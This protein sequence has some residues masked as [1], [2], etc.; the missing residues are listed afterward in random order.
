M[1]ITA[2]SIIKH[3]QI[4]LQDVTGKR[5]PASEL[6][7]YLNMS[8]RDIRDARPDVT[9]TNKVIAL[10]AGH[11]QVLPDD[12]ASLIDIPANAG[13]SKDRISL[14][15]VDLLDAQ[16]P[17]WRAN[18]RATKIQHF[19]YDLLVPNVFYTYPPANVGVQVELEAS[20]YPVDVAEPTV[21]GI[22]FSTVAGNI[23][24][25]DFCESVLR[26]MVLYYAYSKDAEYG[27]NMGLA[28]FYLKIATGLLGVEIKTKVDIKREP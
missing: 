27:G 10:T 8:Q 28:E 25:P 18:A 3:A 14:V 1:A 11:K 17:N 2:Q 24:L 5:W 9:S 21:P 23:G 4:T 13:T 22:L 20:M 6:V 12:V 26:A 15:K 19:M 16:E 7:G